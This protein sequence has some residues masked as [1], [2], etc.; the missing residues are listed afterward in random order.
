MKETSA[1]D[2]INNYKH[3]RLA[4]KYARTMNEAATKYFLDSIYQEDGQSELE[5]ALISVLSHL[6]YYES[7]RHVKLNGIR[8]IYEQYSKLISDAD[9]TLYPEEKENIYKEG[10]AKQVYVNIY[11]RD[12]NARKKCIEYYGYKCC[13]CGI[14]LSD[15]Y[16]VIGRDFIHIHHIKALSAI[17]KEYTVDPISDLRPVC[18]NCHAMIHRREPPYS[19]EELKEIIK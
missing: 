15:K 2:Y 9:L 13:V 19:I 11:E 16:G 1:K 18:P 5:K 7:L 6:N 12:Q 3:M 4:H 17:K 10:K 8:R 14:L